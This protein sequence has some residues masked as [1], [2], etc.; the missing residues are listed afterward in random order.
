MLHEEPPDQAGPNV[1]NGQQQRAGIDAEV[2]VVAVRRVEAERIDE[3]VAALVRVAP[4]QRAFRR[5]R[6]SDM[7]SRSAARLSAGVNMIAEPAA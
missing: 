5:G 2:F 3:A 7:Y 4:Y 1:F 6:A